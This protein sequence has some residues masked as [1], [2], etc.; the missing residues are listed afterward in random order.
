M[1]MPNIF[2]TNF[3]GDPNLG[4]FGFATEK[5][6]VIGP[7]LSSRKR[8]E[9]VLCVRTHECKALGTDLA[10]LFITG[11][12]SGIIAPDILETWEIETLK[13]ISNVLVLKTDFTALGNM[14]L[15]NDKGCLI[16]KLIKN[17]KD[18]IS[19]FLGLECEIAK[20]RFGIIG[21]VAL[22]T[23]TGCV[24]HP[25]IESECAEQISRLLGV[26][27]EAG[28]ANF[29]SPN[30]GACAIANSKGLVASEESTGIEVSRIEE[31][32]FR[33]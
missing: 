16:S 14:I 10:G 9:D 32:L 1:F 19:R 2:Q 7:K 20:S 27:C 31:I 24:V 15:L 28:T 3:L 26:E 4:M 8:L 30:P 11:N 12:S 18:Q 13:K 21:S 5:Y 33:R 25:N 6:C 29:G 23:E 17:Q 22:A